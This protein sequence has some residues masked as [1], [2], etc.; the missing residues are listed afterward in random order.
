[1][2]QTAVQLMS[3]KQRA[4]KLLTGDI[5]L[6][7][8]DALTEGEGG[9]EEALLDAIGR[10]ETLLD[11]TELFKADAQI[12]ALDQED[13]AYWNVEEVALAA[14]DATTDE[15]DALIAAALELGATITPLEPVEPRAEQTADRSA[16]P[17][18]AVSAYLET[19]HIV[20]DEAQWTQRRAELLALLA[21]TAAE[22]IVAWLTEHRVVFPGC[23]REVAEQLL[24]L[25]SVQVEP[26][27]T[28]Q[29]IK[30]ARVAAPKLE[31]KPAREPLVFP[32]REAVPDE[33]FTQ[34]LALF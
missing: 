15:P 31:R 8:L 3:R 1:M 22:G 32:R 14:Q 9:F 24:T 11:P 21:G 2:E 29:L 19:V 25:A 30:P 10:D 4:A 13:A 12:G 20:T 33:A 7:G 5:G 18:E 23:E 28:L 16:H 6:T 34:Q 26:V 17:A 27:P